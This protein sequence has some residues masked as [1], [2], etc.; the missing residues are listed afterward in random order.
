MKILNVITSMRMGGAEKLLTEML[1]IMQ[2][3]GVKSEIFIKFVCDSTGDE[4]YYYWYV[5][6]V[7][8]GGEYMAVLIDIVSGDVI[9]KRP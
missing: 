5:A 8:A 4:S 6:H 3:K 2:E 9:A 7:T 1:P